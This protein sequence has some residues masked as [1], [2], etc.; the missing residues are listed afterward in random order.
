MKKSSWFSGIEDAH[1]NKILTERASKHEAGR[2]PG[3]IF[4]RPPCRGDDCPDWPPDNLP[5]D[6][7]CRGQT[8]VWQPDLAVR[9]IL[10]DRDCPSQADLSLLQQV[11]GGNLSKFQLSDPDVRASCNNRVIDILIWGNRVPSDSCSDLA[12]KRAQ[13]PHD[14]SSGGVFGVYE[15][16]DQRRV[17]I[18]VARA[19]GRLGVH[20]SESAVEKI[21]RASSSTK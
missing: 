4:M 14:I 20:L 7:P 6:D 1:L 5:P 18:F 12:R 3:F 17:D 19:L 13:I 9:L 15:V 21:S 16:P 10:A 11:V 8:W 2:P